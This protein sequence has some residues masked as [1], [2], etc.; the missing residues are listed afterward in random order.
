MINKM[1]HD[2]RAARKGWAPGDYTGSCCDCTER[3]IGA[4]RAYQCAE[5]AYEDWKPTHQHVKR[6]SVYMLLPYTIT[7]E[8]TMIE[9][10]VYQAIS[11][12]CWARPVEEFHDGRF[13]ELSKVKD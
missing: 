4:K 9:H 7:V 8:K 11:G 5:C 3:F 6:G 2:Q 1:A 10:V 12:K 13:V